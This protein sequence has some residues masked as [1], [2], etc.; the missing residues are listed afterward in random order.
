MTVFGS[1]VEFE[2]QRWEWGDF[3]ATSLPFCGLRRTEITLSGFE[4]A[5]KGA[6]RKAISL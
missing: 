5:V 4:E 6:E 1:K 3:M 2:S